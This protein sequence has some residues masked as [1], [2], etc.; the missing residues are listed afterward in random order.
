MMVHMIVIVAPTYTEGQRFQARRAWPAGQEI[1]VIPDDAWA[2]LSL[3]KGDNVRRL[4]TGDQVLTLPGHEHRPD[5]EA[6]Q[7]LLTVM[8][9]RGD[10]GYE[11]RRIL[12]WS[13]DMPDFTDRAAIEAWLT[14]P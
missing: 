5:A 14:H 11:Y 9:K 10:G 13:P 8:T 7:E 2:L 12:D 1:V 6:I 3:T 4:G